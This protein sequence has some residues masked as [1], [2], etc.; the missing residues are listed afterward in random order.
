MDKRNHEVNGVLSVEEELARGRGREYVPC[1]KMRDLSL[2]RA[3]S[4]TVLSSDW[5]KARLLPWH[6]YCDTDYLSKPN[7]YWELC[8]L[9]HNLTMNTTVFFALSISRMGLSLA[10]KFNLFVCI[11]GLTFTFLFFFFFPK[12]PLPDNLVLCSS[13][14]LIQLASY[15]YCWVIQSGLIVSFL[16]LAVSFWRKNSATGAFFKIRK[17]WVSLNMDTARF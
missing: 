8:N 4:S 2:E 14:F 9:I 11:I 5:G 3:G 10:E 7:R 6:Y 1:K 12:E 16:Q 17:T 15:F 13:S